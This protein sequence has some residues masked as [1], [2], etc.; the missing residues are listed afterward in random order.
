MSLHWIEKALPKFITTGRYCGFVM[1]VAVVLGTGAAGPGAL[2]QGDE[3]CWENNC[4]QWPNPEWG[5]LKNVHPGYT[6]TD[7]RPEGFTP[8]VGGMGFLSA[9]RLAE[10]TWSQYQDYNEFGKGE[11]FILEGMTDEDPDNNSVELFAEGFDGTLGLAVVDDEIY[12]RDRKNLKKLADEN[13]D[14]WAE[15]IE[16]GERYDA[17]GHPSVFGLAFSERDDAF[18]TL[19]GT[20]SPASIKGVL[21]EDRQGNRTVFSGGLRNSNGIGQGPEGEIFGTDNQGEWL[22]ANT[23][24]HIQP[25]KFWGYGGGDHIDPPAVYLPQGEAGLSPAEP[26]MVR[27]GQ[28][29]GQMLIADMRLGNIV[30]TFMERLDGVYQGAAFLFSGGFEAGPNRLVWGPDGALYVGGVGAPWGTWYWRINNLYGLQK[31]KENG[32]QVFEMLA[33]RSVPEGFEIEFTEPVSDDAENLSHYQASMWWYQPTAAYGGP[34][35]D[36]TD[37]NITSATVSGDRK[38]V[39]LHMDN[40]IENRVVN[41]KL[42]DFKSAEGKPSWTLETW[43]TLHTKGPADVLGCMDA[44]YEEYN[45]DAVYDDGVQCRNVITAV[46]PASGPST[47]VHE[48][49]QVKRTRIGFTVTVPFNGPYQ[50]VV[51]DIRNRVVFTNTGLAPE[52]FIIPENALK[53]GVYYIGITQGPD[54]YTGRM[55]V[56]Q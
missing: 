27:K 14:G 5:S 44:T 50:A 26:I 11:V 1:L 16:I 47:L 28:F 19:C 39:T 35:M 20:S 12:I 8:L 51:R 13:N 33:V 7:L 2:A 29:A 56:S 53:A 30:R 31:I 48:I 49:I 40:L 3:G 9:G 17:Q 24:I 23:L 4:E 37:L 36:L 55:V 22:P 25:E 43:Y 46:D 42:L 18:Y 10:E 41:I 21:V 54:R 32:Q 38:K 52:G 34:K 45:P 15:V 6:L